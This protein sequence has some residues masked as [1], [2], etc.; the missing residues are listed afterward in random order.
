MAAASVNSR[1]SS[2]KQWGPAINSGTGCQLCPAIGAG[3]RKGERL[4]NGPETQQPDAE[5]ALEPS[6]ALRLEAPLNGVAD[7]GGYVLEI[8]QAAR[9]ARNAFTVVGKTKIVLALRTAPDDVDV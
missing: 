9:T 7:V 5:L 8:R 3:G 1:Q 2:A 4:A 6:R